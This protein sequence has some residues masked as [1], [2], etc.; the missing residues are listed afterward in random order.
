MD[1]ARTPVTPGRVTFVSVDGE[2]PVQVTASCGN[3]FADLGLENA[4]ELLAKADLLMAIK[5]AVRA[6][7]LSRREVARRL[8]K[9]AA[10]VERLFR[11]DLDAVSLYE[12]M[13]LLARLRP[14]QDIAFRPT[15][16]ADSDVAL[17]LTGT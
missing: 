1:T 14:N 8:D 17:R 16:G 6:R 11:G 9:D 4:E 10:M 3:V 5:A 2:E 7:R 13:A 12:L 15:R